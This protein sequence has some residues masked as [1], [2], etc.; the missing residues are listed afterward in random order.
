MFLSEIVSKSCSNYCINARKC[1]K[2]TKH[3]DSVASVNTN[4]ISSCKNIFYFNVHKHIYFVVCNI[5]F[6]IYYIDYHYFIIV[7]N[8]IIIIYIIKLGVRISV[9]YSWPNQQNR[10]KNLYFLKYFFSKF[11]FPFCQLLLLLSLLIPISGSTGMVIVVMVTTDPIIIQHLRNFNLEYIYLL[12]HK[13][14]KAWLLK[15]KIAF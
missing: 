4:C 6:V 7:I 9:P 2:N 10:K 15:T 1:G 12:R 11:I 8:I 3:P 13:I 5:I 14:N